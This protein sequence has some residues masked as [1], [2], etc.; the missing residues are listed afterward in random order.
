MQ[1]INLNLSLDTL[2]G[3]RESLSSYLTLIDS[4]LN[5]EEAP[6]TV[7][8]KRRE[9]ANLAMSELMSAIAE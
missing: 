2:V 6:K 1:K 4:E 3:I 8:T 9:T 5:K 7:L